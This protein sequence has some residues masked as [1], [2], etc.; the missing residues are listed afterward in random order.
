MTVRPGGASKNYDAR[1]STADELS[2]TARVIACAF[3]LAGFAGGT[4]GAFV[5]DLEAPPVAM[6]A[7]GMI[8]ILIGMSGRLPR[9]LKIGDSEAEWEPKV[10]AA[11]GEIADQVP[12]NRLDRVA[13]ALDDLATVAPHAAATVASHVFRGQA[14]IDA[15]RNVARRLGV[16]IDQPTTVNGKTSDMTL[17]ARSGKKLWVTF[18]TTGVRGWQIASAR[19]IMNEVEQADTAY[20]GVILIGSRRSSS[21]ELRETTSGRVWAVEMGDDMDD[22]ELER[23]ITAAFAEQLQP[24]PESCRMGDDGF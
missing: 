10:A 8:F 14:R 11:V 19:E 6:L 7:I 12:P 4:T 17:V 5:T 24:E 13:D 23:V 18:S 1:S 15:L 16:A 22:R 9:R 20:V 3:G 2:T 21:S